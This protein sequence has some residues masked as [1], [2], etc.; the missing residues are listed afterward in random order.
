MINQNR[1]LRYFLPVIAVFTAIIYFLGFKGVFIYDD[2]AQI[3]KKP[4]LHDIFNFHDVIFCGLRQ[5]RVLQNISFALNWT[6]APGETWSFKLFNLLLHLINGSLLFYWLKKVFAD[7]PYLAILATSL[8]L[9]HPLQIQSVTYAMGVIM[10]FHAFFYLLALNWYAKYS[11]TRMPMLMLIVAVSLVARETCAL[12][13]LVLLVYELLIVKTPIRELPKSKWAILFMVPFLIYPLSII[14][15]DPG[16][17]M[18]ASYGGLYPFWTHLASQ[19]YFQCFYL[20]LFINPTLQSL[21]HANPHFDALHILGTVIGVSIWIGGLVFLISKY[22]TRPRATFFVFLFFLNYLPTNSFVQ[23]INP[24]A[25]YRLYLSNL[26]LCVLLAYGLHVLATWLTEKAK[27]TAAHITVPAIAC[28]IFAIFT[29]Q[30][31]MIWKNW[32]LIL[33]QAIKRYPANDY[34]YLIQGI[35]YLHAY[36][37]KNSYNSFN[38]A[39]FLAGR[40]DAELESNLYILAA[41]CYQARDYSLAW[42]IVDQMEKDTQ[43]APLDENFSKFKDELEQKMKS[44]GLSTESH[45]SGNSGVVKAMSTKMLLKGA[46]SATPAH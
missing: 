39:R 27:L 33:A 46:P 5:N 14:L 9:I 7:K 35:E 34:N 25:E 13:P 8:F 44:L 30:N 17:S 4:E 16:A 24:F 1:A 22:K 31:V 10:L 12:I 45:W 32:E 38:Q 6:I 28:S 19:A 37:F 43:K 23:F 41:S 21:I 20:L 18:Y 15:H 42:Q 11:L 29:L 36:D 3:L 2:Y 26:S 40:M